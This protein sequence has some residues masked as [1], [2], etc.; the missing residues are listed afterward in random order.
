MKRIFLK[1]WT[2]RGVMLVVCF[3]TVCT[4]LKSLGK[5]E[6][7][8]GK[9]YNKLINEKSPY[10]LQHA[11]NPV[12]W[13]GWGKEA[14]NRA[15]K[16]DKPIFLSIGYSTCH[17]CHVMAH[18]S[19]ENPEI[20]RLLNDVFVCIKV[21][22]EERPDIDGVYMTVCQMLT[23][24][25]GWPLTIIM[26][27]D[28]KPFFA[29]TY[30]PPE[31]RFGKIGMKELIVQIQE[32]WQ[33]RRTEAVKSAEQI[34]DALN[35]RPQPVAGDG[36]LG[37]QVLE[38]AYN[39]LLQVY[40]E[41]GGGFSRSP[42]F[43]TPHN[44]LFLL[45]YWKQTKN[46]K[47]IEMVEKTITEMRKGGIY[48]HIGFGF[49]RYSTDPAW[50]VPHFEKMLYDQALLAMAYTEAYQATG[51]NDYAAT[52]QEICT[53]IL[54]DMTSPEGGFY[55]AE[56]A[57]SEG[58]EGKFYLWSTGE[59]DSVLTAQEAMVVKK[60]FHMEKE[61]NFYDEAI[62]KKTGTNIVHNKKSL[63]HYAKNLSMTEQLIGETIEESRKKLFLHR[64]KRVHP[65]KDDKILTDWNGLMIAALA[66]AGRVFNEKRFTEAAEKAAE[67]IL[68]QMI[69]KN[70]RILHRYRDGEA[71]IQ[72]HI[73]DYAFMIWGLIELYETTFAVKHLKTAIQVNSVLVDMFW[74]D[75]NG[76]FFVS[77]DD[78]EQLITRQKEIY[79]GAIP[80]GNSVAMLNSL[81]LSR[82]TGDD[83]MEKRA[84]SIAKAFS[85]SII[86][87]PSAHTQFMVALDFAQGPA[88]EVVIVGKEGTQETKQMLGVLGK[89]F[90]PNTVVVFKPQQ[91]QIT[92]IE[93][94]V[95]Y[96]KPHS[97]QNGK[98]TAY[99]CKNFSCR[100]PT[101]DSQEMIKL[102][103]EKK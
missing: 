69:T 91:E 98:A 84:L 100:L 46:Q 66:K 76:G 44:I 34:V 56:D 74:D 31:S 5:E 67:F 85:K 93:K 62:G 19:F 86:S 30:F 80:S 8:K 25:G 14:F 43:P 27:P 28:K 71:A 77:P 49:H 70:G 48:D 87:A 68:K 99:V 10:L 94:I 81:R 21:D 75:A 36:G 58:V 18:E 39:D 6:K 54:R 95:P 26:T 33:T 4:A 23:G 20:A 52:A 60:V 13:Y 17:W 57:D 47:A 101:T 35:R 22:R 11:E 103:K 9:T 29:G 24:S 50:L 73:D 90:L 7:M 78:G 16:E 32:I 53:Y 83:S 51:K 41:Q 63:E 37:K 89:T 72:A 12:D 38:Q 102:L 61:G 96:S 42:K 92:D 15:R 3:V 79:D 64:D 88:Y 59:I 1:Q 65:H 82:I 2:G 97:T 40:D 45:R 55:S